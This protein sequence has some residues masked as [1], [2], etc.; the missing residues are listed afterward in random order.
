[1]AKYISFLRGINVGGHK[2][3]KM[4]QL[5]VCYK[6]LGFKNVITYIQSGNVIFEVDETDPSKLENL[7][8][9][10]IEQTFGFSVT[11]LIRTKIEFKRIL[12]NNPFLRKRKEDIIK[13]NVTFLSETPSENSLEPIE[14]FRDKSEELLLAGKEIYLFFSNGLGRTKLSNTLMEKKLKVMTTTRNWK[15]VNK[16]YELVK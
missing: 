9:N 4:D 15:T 16:L 1:M 12:E 2:K 11:A 3:I 8:E 13:L 10:K 7:I 6:S 5:K 14:K